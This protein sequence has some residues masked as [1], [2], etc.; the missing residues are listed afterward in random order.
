MKKRIVLKRLS[1]RCYLSFADECSKS[2]LPD[3]KYTFRAYAPFKIV[4][5]DSEEEAIKAYAD[6]CKHHCVENVQLISIISEL[7]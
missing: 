3:C 6:F 4:K 1:D 5:F 7:S 2:M